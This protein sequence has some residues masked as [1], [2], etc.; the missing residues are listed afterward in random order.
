MGV[1]SN[2]YIGRQGA[3][4]YAGDGFQG[5]LIVGCGLTF[6]DTEILLHQFKYG[7]STAHMACCT[8]TH[9]DNLFSPRCCVELF[10]KSDH[11]LHLRG[12]ESEALFGAILLG[13]AVLLMFI[14]RE[15]RDDS[16]MHMP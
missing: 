16:D 6:F 7:F 13:V 8:P 5:V 11:S 9:S 15:K 10:V 4:A 1:L 12:K 14:G 2:D 3:N